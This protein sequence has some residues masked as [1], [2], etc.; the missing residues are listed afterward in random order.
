[1]KGKGRGEEF[2]EKSSEVYFTNVTDKIPH[3]TEREI[4]LMKLAFSTGYNAGACHGEDVFIQE[5]MIQVL[6]I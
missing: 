3:L 1:M 4:E 5:A 2:K 6:S